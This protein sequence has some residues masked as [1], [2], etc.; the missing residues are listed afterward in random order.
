MSIVDELLAA[1]RATAQS[2]MDTTV[3]ISRKTG[4]VPNQQTGKLEATWTEVYK[5]PAR[6]RLTGSDPRDVDAAGQRFAIQDPT[7][8]LPVGDD[9]RIEVGSSA[10]VRVDDEGVVLSNE[11]DSGEVGTTFR[12]DGR[13]GQTHST[14][15]RLR[16]EVLSHAGN[17]S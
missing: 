13:V 3:R 14:A 1:G 15:R 9:P 10:D 4:Q 11:H 12:I 17:H 16:A 2:L 7:V 8:S 5:G 6:V